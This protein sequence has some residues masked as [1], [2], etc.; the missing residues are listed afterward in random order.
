MVTYT[1]N[2]Y[3]YATPLSSATSFVSE[4]SNVNDVKYFTLHNNKLDGTYHLASGDAG[5]WGNVISDFNGVLSEPF[6]INV[7]GISSMHSVR[8]VGS[9]HCYPVDFTIDIYNDDT[10]VYTIIEEENSDVNYMYAF[11]KLLYAT[12]YVVTITRISAP[13]N[14]AK[15][16]N[17][18]NPNYIVRNDKLTINNREIT[19]PSNVSYYYKSDYNYITF[20]EISHI[21]NIINRTKDVL[22]FTG[23]DTP[24]LTNVHTR[25]KDISRSVYGK[26]YITYTD[27]MLE[28]DT[29]IET[30][31][32]AYNSDKEQVMDDIASPDELFF[33][34]YDNDLSGRYKVMTS[35]SQVGWVSGI[36]S[37]DEG[38]FEEAP[39]LR[40]SFSTRPLTPLTVHFDDSHGSVADSFEVEFV[41]TDNE[42]IIKTFTNNTAGKVLINEDVVQGVN[43]V[44]IRVHKTTKPNFPVGIIEVPILSTILY[45]GYAD[46]SDLMS[47]DMLEELTYED[48]VEA[49]GGV[50]ANEVTVA[51]DNSKRSFYFNNENSVV[52][53]QL[54]RN[55]RI[56]PWLGTEIIPGTIEWYKLGIYWSYKWDVPVNSLVAKVIGF[57]T[58]GLLDTTDFT[59]HYVQVDKSLGELIEY[60][61]SDAKQSLYFI[62]WKIDP[63]LYGVRIPYAWFANGSH[64]AA[65]RKISQSYPMHIYCDRD[66]TICAA[67]QK[68]K[69]DYYYDTWSDNTN[70]ISK[71]YS[72]LYT[73][74]PN[75]VTVN[76]HIPQVIE[77][78]SLVQDNLAF[79]VT[80][81]PT[82]TLNFSKPYIS[83]ISVD[84]DKD[85]TVSYEYKAYSWG[86]VFTFTGTG[87]VR[88]ISCTGDS[89]DISNTSLLTRRNE[90]SV[91][92][93]GAVTRDVTADFIQTS[94][95]A[96]LILDRIF[97]L[98]ANDK[99]DATVTYRGDIALSINDPIRLLD[100]IA[101]D[102]RYNIRRHQLSWNGALHGTADLNT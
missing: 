49:L 47:V 40:I 67:P 34:L 14:V 33:T 28:N 24:T 84:I 32:E 62:N 5:L 95:L 61:L 75:I 50:S 48:E 18:Y 92:A 57:D 25:M 72:S 79:S 64:T 71:E 90:E 29:T 4:V 42:S 63:A 21:T 60:V 45:A 83:G 89:V 94:E 81:T 16:Y 96:T 91:R 73:T 36:A 77:N 46:K 44:I 1:V 6:I 20:D 102:N 88:S 9:A 58:L 51:L 85:D 99:Y 26:V 52:S 53:K 37:N 35:D 56:E 17:T 93:D 74:L 8:V 27:P 54:R 19:L 65:L 39:Y 78:D 86:I 59:H 69:L 30:N 98:S 76:V 66:G 31:M 23:I 68:L 12:N 101:P 10:L 2:Q 82:R 100:G 22:H 11:P 97:N 87:M 3:N 15:V 80:A 7:E 43:T 55:R 38:I 41:R 70:V 13:N